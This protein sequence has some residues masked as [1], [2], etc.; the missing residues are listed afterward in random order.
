MRGQ[1]QPDSGAQTVIVP[2]PPVPERLIQHRRSDPAELGPYAVAVTSGD[3]AGQIG[4]DVFADYE[5]A[6]K[7]YEQ[8]A[9][10]AICVEAKSR[11]QKA[12][13]YAAMNVYYRP[14]DP[15]G[16]VFRGAL[17]GYYKMMFP[18]DKEE[19]DYFLQKY[20]LEE[21][22]LPE[23]LRSLYGLEEELS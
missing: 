4:S 10:D 5:E 3:A 23:R 16:I 19:N 17:S 20:S 22:I 12:H 1:E 21:P 15:K 14:V 6:S 9:F 2:L 11:W 7:L 18:E 8:V 13:I